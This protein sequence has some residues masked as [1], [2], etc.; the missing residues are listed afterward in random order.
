[1]TARASGTVAMP[2]WSLAV[3]AMLSVQL[4]SALSV[5]LISAVGPAG[6]SWLRL[7][8]GR[9]RLPDPGPPP[10]RAI[11]LHDVPALTGLAAAAG[12]ALLLPVFP[13][14]LEMLALRRMRPAASGPLM[15]LQPAIGVPLGLIG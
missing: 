13:Y 8:I 6:T 11:R 14:A 7:S 15:A 2:P 12:L 4:A 5:H 10:L 1:M 3:A 9:T